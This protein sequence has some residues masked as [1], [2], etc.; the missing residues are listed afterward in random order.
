MTYVIIRF[1]YTNYRAIAYMSRSDTAAQ[2]HGE[3]GALGTA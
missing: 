2:A 3:K 1:R